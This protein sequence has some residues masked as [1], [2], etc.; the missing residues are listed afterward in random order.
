MKKKLIALIATIM[1]ML[2]T[3]CGCS[4]KFIS[5]RFFVVENLG[6]Q[7]SLEY[8]VCDRETGV[9]YLYKEEGYR[10]VMTVLL[11]KDGKPLLYEGELK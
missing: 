11:D 9:L 10:A 8:I 3:L 1:L 6:T 7:G 5:D 2:F 4:G